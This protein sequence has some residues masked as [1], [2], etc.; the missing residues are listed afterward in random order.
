MAVII[1]GASGF[2]G[3][4]LMAYYTQKNI[5]TTGTYAHNKI[6]GLI[7]CDLAK[8]DLTGLN[9]DFRGVRGAII[10]SAITGMDMC[11]TDWAGTYKINVSGVKRLIALLH[12]MKITPVFIST[13]YVFDGRAGNYSEDDVRS[14]ALAYGRQKK[15]VEDYLMHCGGNYIIARLARMYGLSEDRKTLL[16]S[17]AGDLRMGKTLALATDQVFSPTFVGDVCRAIDILMEKE[18]TGCIHIC[19]GEAIARYALARLIKSELKIKTGKLTPCCLKD[20]KFGDNRPLNT[21]MNNQKCVNLTNMRFTTLGEAI[22]KLKYSG[23]IDVR[24]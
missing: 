23:N 19:A 17:I 6:K 4:E 11:R 16:H 2:L 10:C 8:P 13:D 18:F 20:L 3:G 9:V 7:K 21:S 22:E 15:E 24:S 12:D 14:P 5:R 1:F